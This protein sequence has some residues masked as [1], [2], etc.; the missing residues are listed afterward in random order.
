M[1][2]KHYITIAIILLT[3][4][5]YFC[6]KG[7]IPFSPPGIKVKC[8]NKTIPALKGEFTWI[9][10]NIGGNSTFAEDWPPIMAKKL[11][12]FKVKKGDIIEF[13]F[14]AW[15]SGPKSCTVQ[16]IIP[17]ENIKPHGYKTSKITIIENNKFKVPEEKGIYIYSICGS[18]DDSHGIEYIIKVE[19]I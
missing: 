10:K 12:N 15:E 8:N 2:R 4:V 11:D 3:L 9:D 14:L 16:R 18:W 19:V 5:S 13:N 17:D 7:N 6:L 1:K